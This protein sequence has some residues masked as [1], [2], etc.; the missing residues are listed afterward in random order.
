[1]CI[2]LRIRSLNKHLFRANIGTYRVPGTVRPTRS[3]RISQYGLSLMERQC[4]AEPRNQASCHQSHSSTEGN[5]LRQKRH[6]SP[7]TF[8]HALT[9]SC[10][11]FQR[12]Q[13]KQSHRPPFPCGCRNILTDQGHSTLEHAPQVFW[14]ASFFSFLFN[15]YLFLRDRGRQSA[16]RGRAEREG[17]TESP[18][19]S[20]L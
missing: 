3:T 11:G 15:M 12:N 10:M 16:S 9:L 6:R 14:A 8:S 19:G 18:A 5:V 7:P 2:R 20:R 1:M 13:K 4:K 17:D